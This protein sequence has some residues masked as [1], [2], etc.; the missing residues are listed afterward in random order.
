MPKAIL[1]VQANSS[2]PDREDEFNRWYS[3]T[4][5]PDVLRVDGY[6]AAQRF[7]LVEGLPLA[8]GLPLPPHRYLAVYELETDD[9]E[10]AA[11]R[12]RDQVLQGAIGI[13]DTL[14]LQSVSVSFYTPITDRLTSEDSRP[15]VGG[16]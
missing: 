14:D 15:D 5:L 7:R 12:L 6:S 1:V 3:E 16:G 11:Q 9:L 13:S 2:S 8:E 10:A 4:H